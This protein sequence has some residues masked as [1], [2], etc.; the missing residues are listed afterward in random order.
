MEP[1][2]VRQETFIFKEYNN[3]LKNVCNIPRLDA[4]EWSKFLDPEKNVWISINEPG[5]TQT[6]VQ[7]TVLESLP[8]LRLDFWDIE[9]PINDIKTRETIYPVSDTDIGKIVRFI[10]TH[11]GK[12]FIVNCAAG[13][14]RS[15]AIAKFLV[16]FLEYNWT[17]FGKDRT[18]RKDGLHHNKLVYDKVRREY[19]SK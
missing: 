7:N 4:R 13:V 6:V 16:D 2:H 19:F 10:K 9:S 17:V 1:L 15:G 8:H 11:E 5:L 18:D 14:S 12:N 3:T